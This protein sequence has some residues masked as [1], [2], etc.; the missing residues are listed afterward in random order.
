MLSIERAKGKVLALSTLFLAGIVWA[1]PSLAQCL[2]GSAEQCQTLLAGQT[3]DAGTVCVTVI[4]DDLVVTFNAAN[5]WVLAETHLWVGD[6]MSDYPQTRK[7]NPKIGNFPYPSGDITGET[8]YMTVISL[9][10]LGFN[11][12]TD[13][14]D[15]FIAAHAVVE[16]P[17]GS[18]GFKTETA[19]ADGDKFVERGP[20]GTFFMVTLS[21]D[22]GG[23][24]GNGGGNAVCETAF[25]VLNVE[26]SDMSSDGVSGETSACFL[27]IDEDGVANGDGQGA[28]NRWGWSTCDIPLFATTFLSLRVGATGCDTNNGLEVGYA[29]IMYS[30]TATQNPDGTFTK[31]R[32]AKVTFQLTEPGYWLKEA[33]VYVGEEILPRSAD[34]LLTVSPGDYTTIHE[35]LDNNGTMPTLE[36]I[37]VDVTHLN[38][39][40]ICAI[41]HAVVCTI[42]PSVL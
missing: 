6:D 40:D 41:V 37:I 4:G 1:G 22:C 26:K 33:H 35:G 38:E 42:D 10:L 5:G 2:S 14:D 9:A 39:A 17:D 29:T 18:G 34:G 32:F 24:S 11:C 15:F 21:C 23:G 30:S 28:F 8:T 16:Q 12:P 31:F 7:G 3:T 20:W 19:W 25:G 36:T 13:V 27:D